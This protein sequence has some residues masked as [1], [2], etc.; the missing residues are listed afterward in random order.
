MPATRQRLSPATRREQIAAAAADVFADRDPAEVSFDEVARAA[1][2]SRSLVYKYFGDRQNLL[3]AAYLHDLESLDR[4]ISSALEGIDDDEERLRAVI[5][6]YLDFARHNRGSSHLISQLGTLRHPAVQA[7][8]EARV[9]R[10]ISQVGGQA[11]A[12]VVA[13]GIVALLESAAVY[14]VDHSPGDADE[15]T[16]LLFRVLRGG[17][18]EVADDL[19]I[20]HA[21]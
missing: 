8:T 5:A 12:T 7:A 14:W 17:L 19:G 4:H 10:L 6:A 16:D 9:E 2:V 1:G 13:R 20:S 21:S 18:V 3:A 15:V 11:G